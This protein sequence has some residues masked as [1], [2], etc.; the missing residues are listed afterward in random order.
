MQAYENN[1]YANGGKKVENKKTVVKKAEESTQ[2]PFTDP[3]PKEK[4][5][6]E[7]VNLNLVKPIK[8]R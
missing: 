5:N 2:L 8:S 3:L 7:F 4:E 1:Y 6:V